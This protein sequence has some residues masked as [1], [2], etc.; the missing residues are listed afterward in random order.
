MFGAFTSYN[1]C[2]AFK[3]YTT[4]S[5]AL[6]S[7]S[8]YSG[9]N[10]AQM[11]NTCYFLNTTG[12][13]FNA[14]NTTNNLIPIQTLQTTYAAATP[15]PTFFSVVSNI[16][17]TLVNFMANPNQA[18]LVNATTAQN[19]IT[20]LNQA[21]L[22]ASNGGGQTCSAVNDTFVYNSVNCYP[23]QIN[24]VTQYILSLLQIPHAS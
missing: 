17:N 8:F 5:T 2:Q 20:A 6:T 1:G 3:T 19:P 15:N 18:N 10:I 16:Q 13:V 24:Q 4:N 7:L 11:I 9:S 14:F 21:N 22:Y 23:L 12:T